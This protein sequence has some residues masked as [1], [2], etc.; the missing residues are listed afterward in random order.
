MLNTRRW[1]YAGML[2]LC[3]ILSAGLVPVAGAQPAAETP[4]AAPS[5]DGERQPGVITRDDLAG[6][7]ERYIQRES[8]IQNGHFLFFDRETNQ[9]VALTFQNVQK[10]TIERLSEDRYTATAVMKNQ[11]G[12]EVL[13]DIAMKYLGND[14]LKVTEVTR[15]REGG[16]PPEFVWDEEQ[17]N[18][19][20]R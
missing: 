20:K 14:Q 6:A 3:A 12:E 10:D 7:V 11:A 13:L 5:P 17:G 4:A 16:E 1:R 2:G 18:W 9:P 15:H 19:K 8:E